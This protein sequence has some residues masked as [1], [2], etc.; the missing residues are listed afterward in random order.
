MFFHVSS[1]S[2]SQQ[3]WEWKKSRHVFLKSVVLSTWARQFEFLKLKVFTFK[4]Q[5]CQQVDKEGFFS[6]ITHLWFGSVKFVNKSTSGESFKKAFSLFFH[7][8]TLSTSQQTGPGRVLSKRCHLWFSHVKFVNKSTSWNFFQK[9]SFCILKC[10][11][12]QQVNKQGF[13]S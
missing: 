12:C 10:Q 9:F 2:T 6:K 7:V 8:S 13:F 11:I 5:I 1:L 3:A 4:C